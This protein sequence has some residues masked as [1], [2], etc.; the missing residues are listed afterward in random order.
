MAIAFDRF[1]KAADILQGFA[2]GPIPLAR[3]GDFCE[4]DAAELAKLD[5]VALF[6]VARDTPAALSGLMLFAGCWEQSHELSQEN[7]SKEGSYWHGIAHR[8]EPDSSNA[9]YWFRRVGEHPIFPELQRQA[10]AILAEHKNLHWTLPARWDPH[11]FLERCDEA[12]AGRSPE[13]VKAAIE[14]QDVECR[15]LLAWCAEPNA[16][17]S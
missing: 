2:R 12:R 9:A 5:P 11:W 17:E 15:L 4:R 10:A 14:I 3:G 6:P 1:P 8:I 13:A 16:S 7:P